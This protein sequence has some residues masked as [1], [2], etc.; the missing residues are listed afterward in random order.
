MNKDIEGGRRAQT[1]KS[2]GR[3]ND[4]EEESKDEDN[5]YSQDYDMGMGGGT[6]YGGN[7]SGNQE[8]GIDIIET[9]FSRQR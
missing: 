4:P 1:S 9:P 8:S 2:L 6:M 7:V 5:Q 3:M